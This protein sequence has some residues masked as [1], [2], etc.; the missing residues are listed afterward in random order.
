MSDGTD[1]IP[2]LRTSRFGGGY[3]RD[4]VEQALRGL[5][6]TVQTAET[7]LQEVRARS[8]Q[9]DRELAAAR[10]EVEAY[11]AREQDLRELLARA[12][13]LLEQAERKAGVVPPSE[14]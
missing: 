9:L 7:N 12:E 5:L 1:G 11:Q 10:A 2:T 3:R 14:A 8:S 4:D 6:A 13:E